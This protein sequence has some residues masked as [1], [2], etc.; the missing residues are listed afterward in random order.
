[1]FIF[2]LTS[3]EGFGANSISLGRL[4]GR[5]SNDLANPAR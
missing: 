4:R 2:C 3:L 5:G 1:M